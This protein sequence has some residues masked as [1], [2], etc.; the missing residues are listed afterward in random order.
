L[1]EFITIFSHTLCA[2]RDF[3]FSNTQPFCSDQKRVRREKNFMQKA[4]SKKNWTITSTAL[5]RLLGWLDA[6][7]DSDGR[8]YLEMRQRLVSYFDRKNCLNADELADETLNR[9]ARRLEEE[10]KI[11]SE[12]PAKYCY[13]TAK[14]VFM[15]SLRGADKKNVPLDD[16][17]KQPQANELMAANE[18]EEKK[19][20]EKM[21]DCLEKCTGKLEAA[22]R[23]II[24]NYYYGE[25][26][27]KIENRRAL[28]G[29]LGISTNALTIRACRIR[30]KL[31]SCVG[32]CVGEK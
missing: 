10:G 1:L 17:L 14:F 6:G 21:L 27:I 5:A 28:A 30:D 20:K 31:E 32:K 24:V 29:K 15:E 22:N 2:V 12:T 23:D 7:N 3:A 11:E 16:V 18:G 19:L 4:E 8:V 26:R 13:I 9:V 25:E